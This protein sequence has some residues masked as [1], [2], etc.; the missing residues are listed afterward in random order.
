MP[1]IDIFKTP[2][3]E[4]QELLKDLWKSNRRIWRTVAKK[5]AKRRKD[6]ISVNLS[7][8]N[9]LGRE[10]ETVIIPGKVLALG[11]INKKLLIAAYSF[12][13]DCFEKVKKAKG[14]CITIQ[15]LMKRNPEGK[16]I[17]IIV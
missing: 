5:L 13:N 12:S 8:I 4:K 9:K 14:E 7:K 1:K 16:N 15:E 17:R 6:Q 3:P 2:N 11:D 10:N